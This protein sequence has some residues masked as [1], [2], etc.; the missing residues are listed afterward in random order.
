MGACPLSILLFF[1]GICSEI[2]VSE[3]LYYTGAVALCAAANEFP[4]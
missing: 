2:E 4:I 1:S 3:Q